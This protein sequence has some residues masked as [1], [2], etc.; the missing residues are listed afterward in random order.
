MKFLCLLAAVSALFLGAGGGADT[1]PPTL[2]SATVN[3]LG[4]T[5]TLVFSEAVHS[6]NWSSGSIH[7]LNGD[8]QISNDQDGGGAQDGS[9]FR[10]TGGDGT[11]TIVA[12]VTKPVASPGVNLGDSLNIS[13]VANLSTVTDLAGNQLAD[14]TIEDNFAVTNNSTH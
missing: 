5:L 2:V 8:F 13:Y 10:Y 14:I 9:H 3:T 11:N 6:G 7:D 4:T 1:T 12:D